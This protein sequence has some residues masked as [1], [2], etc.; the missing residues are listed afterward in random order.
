MNNLAPGDLVWI[1]ADT[2]M[3]YENA[4]AVG[5]SKVPTFGLVLN[6]RSIM[7]E[8][9]VIVLRHNEKVSIKRKHLRRIDCMEVTNDTANRSC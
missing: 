8:N 3:E 2:P 5:R 9:H 6:N 1:P 7:W 4:F